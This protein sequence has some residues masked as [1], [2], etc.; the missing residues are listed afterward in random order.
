LKKILCEALSSREEGR[1]KEENE[2]EVEE[3]R[4]AVE[5]VEESEALS[6]SPLS[7]LFLLPPFF[8]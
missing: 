4:E 6:L 2:E 3:E 1:V 8:L 5:W 7:L